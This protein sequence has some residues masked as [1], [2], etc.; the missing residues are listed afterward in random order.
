MCNPLIFAGSLVFLPCVFAGGS[1]PRSAP[2]T[3]TKKRVRRCKRTA[4]SD[5]EEEVVVPTK[6]TRCEKSAAA[7]QRVIMPLH[8]WK[9]KEW[10]AFQKKNPYTVPF[11]PRQT[12]LWYA[13]VVSK[14]FSPLSGT[15]FG[16]VTKWVWAMGGGVLPTR[17]RTRQG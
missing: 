5:G 17:P 3:K 6:P 8:K 4:E 13:S 10:D 15:T 16:T 12:S 11:A 7:K 1:S 14:R 2:R 9:A